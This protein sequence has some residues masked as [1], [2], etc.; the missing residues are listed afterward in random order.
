MDRAHLFVPFSLGKVEFSRH[1]SI[2]G[3][4]SQSPGAEGTPLV[5]GPQRQGNW[6]PHQISVSMKNDFCLR[7]PAPRAGT[8]DARALSLAARWLVRR[9]DGGPD[10]LYRPDGS[11]VGEL[12]NR[13]KNGTVSARSTS[14][15]YVDSELGNACNLHVA[16]HLDQR[17]SLPSRRLKLSPATRRN[18]AAGR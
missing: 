18:F 4:F 17:L 1:L 6:T 14:H 13:A 5:K 11:T 16:Q 9:K 10:R 15:F 3:I 8:V 12:M 2:R 7:G